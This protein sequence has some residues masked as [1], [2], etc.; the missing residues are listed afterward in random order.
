MCKRQ[1]GLRQGTAA[2]RRVFVGGRWGA[3]GQRYIALEGDLGRFILLLLQ[4]QGA[5]QQPTFCQIS[6][7]FCQQAELGLGFWIA[8]QLCQCTGVAHADFWC[9]LFFQVL[10]Y[11][12]L[13]VRLFARH[14][15]QC[16]K[17]GTRGAG[18]AGQR[19]LRG[20]KGSSQIVIAQPHSSYGGP[21]RAAG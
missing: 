4:L 20:F 2:I 7:V 21:G 18:V 17:S 9:G 11:Q 6:F 1:V 10:H 15:F 19:A 12:R 16:Q 5:Q 13:C 14:Q 3:F 8:P